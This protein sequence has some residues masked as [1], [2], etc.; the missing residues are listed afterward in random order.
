LN[1]G[2]TA[3]SYS[4]RKGESSMLIGKKIQQLRLKYGLT[5]EDLADR[6]ELSKGFISQLERDLTSPSIATLMDILQ[7]LGISIQEFFTEERM[8]TVVFTPA[9][10]FTKEDEQE[11]TSVTWLVPHAQKNRME[12]IL[13]TL[14][15]KKSS[16]PD[17]PHEGEEFGYM[18][19]GNATLLLGNQKY[20]IKKGDSFCFT[21]SMAH[22]FYNHG[23]TKIVVLWVSAPPSF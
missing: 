13:F 9:D 20:R 22:G 3:A 5:Q 19:A 23:N 14:D 15:P 7:C 10:L 12:P 2:L 21:P 8:E 6:A 18:L 1:G 16:A 11:G 4:C 17:V